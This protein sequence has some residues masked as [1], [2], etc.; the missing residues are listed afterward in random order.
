MPKYYL[1][2]ESSSK[3]IDPSSWDQGVTA[4]QL[5]YD[6]NISSSS[7]NNQ[8]YTNGY[9]GLNMGLN[10]GRV[11]LRH[12]G[13]LTWSSENGGR[14][15]RG[16]IYG[17]TDLTDWN[18]Q[19]LAGE[20]STSG[21]FFDAMSFRGFQVESDD[22]MLPQSQRFYA[23]VVRGTAS[24]N[25][26][27]TIYQRGYLVYETTVAPGPFE[28]ADLQA[29]SFGGDLQV[30]VTEAN[31]QKSSFMVPFATT[32]QLL[33]PGRTRFSATVG[34]VAEQS[35]NGAR[36]YMLQGTVQRGLDN[37]LTGYGGTALT[38][39]YLSGMLGTALNTPIGGFAVDLTMASTDLGNDQR[40]QG[41]SLRLSYSKNLPNTGTHFSLLA[42]RYSTSG[43]LGLRDAIALQ[44][45]IA[46]DS[47]RG[48]DY[49][50]MRSRLDTNIS[51]QFAGEGGSVYLSGSSIQY[52]NKASQAQSFSLG[53]TNQWRG[54]S[55]SLSA[56]RTQGTGGGWASGAGSNG[57]T[58]ISL[59]VSIPLGRESRSGTTFNSFASRDNYSGTSVSS[60]LSG[61]LDEAG[62]G[63]YALS[64]ARD[65]EAHDISNNAS[66]NYRMPKVSLGA[67]LSRGRDY[68][69]GSLSAS[70]AM[71]A[72]SG[73]VTFSQS[74]GETIGVVKAPGAQGAQVGYGVST[75]DSRGYAVLTSL[76]PYQ[77]NNVEI[78]PNGMPDD[79]ELK[80]SSRSVA[81]RA[82]A[83]VLLDYPTLRS[84]PV[85][86][87]SKRENGDRLP[88]AAT[89]IDVQSGETVGAVGQGSRL[90]IRTEKDRGSIRVEWGEESGQQCQVDYQLPQRQGEKRSGYDML[91]LPCRPVDAA[92]KRSAQEPQF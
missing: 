79:V 25:A 78:D 46:R 10:I 29:A 36:P 6:S 22:R 5:T 60:G 45:V 89:A 76:T 53:Y 39:D 56:Q 28:I 91:E 30:T 66:L 64:V 3:D 20:S 50:R 48:A 47:L 27:V 26:R 37:Q 34:Q 1:S 9:A 14:Y 52:W 84:R 18:A 57:N 62:H 31:G 21:E 82:G 7:S 32:V 4:A 81:P 90:V 43:F 92:H 59:S 19:I 68:Q 70:G 63:A 15:Q 86:I 23:P 51:Q 44:D 85:L 13:N 2:R 80:V 17:Q 12:R 8:R 71:I 74:L 61:T 24:S 38:R 42:Y 49:G 11:H 33:R 83:V 55:Y 16:N 35:L 73:G 72:H 88:F 40:R 41:S 67:S 65:G 77:L 69:Q 54:N 75:V 58:L 87:N